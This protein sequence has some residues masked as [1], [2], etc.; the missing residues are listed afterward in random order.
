MRKGTAERVAILRQMY[1]THTAQEC[2][3]ALGVTENYV[4]WLV[5]RFGI[6]T[7]HMQWTQELDDY[8][9]QHFGTTTTKEL[10]DKMG[11][12][13]ARVQCRARTLGL[14][15]EDEFRRKTL[16]VLRNTLVAD[17]RRRIER[18]LPQRTR[19]PV[20]HLSR[21]QYIARYKLVK[22]GY[23][24]DYDYRIAYYTDKTERHTRF[25]ANHADLF[26]IKPWTP[27]VAALYE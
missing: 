5:H 23:Y 24:C 2:A 13:Y 4:H 26:T 1:P 6:L 9:R 22:W 3:R 25:E 12:T 16:S 14:R 17:E 27:E 10:A 15:K 18:G 19:L 20:T 8:L 11:L 7:K 21:R